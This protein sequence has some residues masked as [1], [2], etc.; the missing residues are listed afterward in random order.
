MKYL[1]YFENLDEYDFGITEEE[2]EDIFNDFRDDDFSIKVFFGKQ[3]SRTFSALNV[4]T[5][6]QEIELGYVPFI[7]VKLISNLYKFNNNG[8]IPDYVMSDEFKKIKKEIE[9]RLLSY[10]LTI[11]NISIAGNEIY[12]LIYNKNQS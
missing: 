4:K 11:Q 3:L 10:N 6:N 7:K 1:K 2:V 5:T 9:F 12:F 8:K